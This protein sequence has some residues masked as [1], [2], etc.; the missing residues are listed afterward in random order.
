MYEAFDVVEGRRNTLDEFDSVH[1]VAW[2]HAENCTHSACATPTAGN[3]TE[4]LEHGGQAD[5][6]ARSC[7]DEEAMLQANV[8]WGI[9][10]C[11]A[12]P[13]FMSSCAACA[14]SMEAL[15]RKE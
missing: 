5:L 14:G 3:M 13:A 10:V 2:V 11:P 12:Y 9:G 15:L 8:P 4:L 7:L 1:A 6:G